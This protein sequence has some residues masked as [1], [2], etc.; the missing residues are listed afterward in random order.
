MIYIC[1]ER[2]F[3]SLVRREIARSL[4]KILSG[5]L[6]GG[7]SEAQPGTQSFLYTLLL[8]TVW[9]A[10]SAIAGIET[11]AAA[12]FRAFCYDPMRTE[13]RLER[14]DLSQGWSI[15]E[16]DPETGPAFLKG[17]EGDTYIRTLATG[18]TQLLLIQDS[19]AVDAGSDSQALRRVSCRLIHMG[20]VKAGALASYL[21]ERVFP[22][23]GYRMDSGHKMSLHL[24][25]GWGE[26][27]WSVMPRRDMGAWKLEEHNNY[28]RRS[29][30]IYFTNSKQYNYTDLVTIRVAEKAGATGILLLQLDRTFK[31]RDA[32]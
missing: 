24:P 18:E 27:C 13:R 16:I 19:G 30:C 6:N 12:A 3:L 17:F 7:S 26:W 9:G 8:A 14:P 2:P 10:P 32:D 1:G 15:A 29:A 28:P 5:R 11:E 22:L 21:A 31:P 23:N 25:A 20:E 4:G